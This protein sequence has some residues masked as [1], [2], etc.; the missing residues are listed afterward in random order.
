MNKPLALLG[1]ACIA[2]CLGVGSAWPEAGPA[3]AS[4][5]TKGVP[6]TAHPKGHYAALDALPD[7]GGVWV[8]NFP[9]PVSPRPEKPQLKGQYLADYQAWQHEVESKGGEVAHAGSYCTPPGMPGI[10]GVGQYPIEFLFTPGR[11]TTHHEA[12]MQWRNIYTDG[13]AHPDDLDP[14]FQGDSIGHW[15]GQTLVVDTIGVKDSVALGMGMK[16]SDKMHI[17]E[18]MHL[19][20]DDPDTL[21]IEMKVEDPVALAKPWLHTLSFKRSREL[22][23]LE[24]ECAEND[25]NPVD[26]SGNTGYKRE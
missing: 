7:W 25:R 18:R 8:L 1:A 22:Q 12:W 17:T 11:V 23:L 10:M 13:R 9:P 3:S 19:A 4:E 24:F 6:V 16:H 15:E 5:K 26:A 20:K 14:T 2:L 21:V